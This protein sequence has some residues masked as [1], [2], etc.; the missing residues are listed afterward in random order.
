MPSD[1]IEFALDIQGALQKMN[2]TQYRE[3]IQSI[4]QIVPLVRK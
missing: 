3:V 4:Q 2:Y 1:N